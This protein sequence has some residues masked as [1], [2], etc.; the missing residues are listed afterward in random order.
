MSDQ[1]ARLEALL[2]AATD[3][4]WDRQTVLS[5]FTFGPHTSEAGSDERRAEVAT[6]YARQELAAEAVS[7][8]PLLIAVAKAARVIQSNEQVD[9]GDLVYAVRERE[10]EGW[11][12]ASVIAWSDA[13]EALGKSLAK[14]DT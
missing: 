6:R 1:L 9:L 14:L 2:A 3:L 8:L 4:P 7:S 12:G 10:G 13:V 11:E 5:L